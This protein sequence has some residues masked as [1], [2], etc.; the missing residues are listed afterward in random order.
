VIDGGS[1]DGTVDIIRSHEAGIAKWVSEKDGGIA[2]AFNKGYSFSTGSYLLFLNA[3]DALANPEVIEIAAKQIVENDFPAFLYGDCDVLDRNSDRVLY[4]ACIATSREKLLRGHMIPQ[5]SLFV[6]RSYFEKYGV[7]DLHFKIAM[8]YEWLLRGG[9]TERIVHVPMLVTNVRDGG[10]STLDRQRVVEEVISALK[11][12]GY[13]SS[14]W[15]E[16]EMRGH[17]A[18]RSLARS[19]LESVGLYRIFLG[20]KKNNQ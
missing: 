20:L 9:L 10:I 15:A 17:Y 19:V 5:P 13:V 16:L 4:R 11:K 6:R 7:F 12:N 3:D 2:D 14:G 8:D 1:T 18:M